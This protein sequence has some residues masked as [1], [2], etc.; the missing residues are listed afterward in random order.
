MVVVVLEFLACA[1]AG[2]VWCVVCGVWCSDVDM[3]CIG[4][5][6]T[7]VTF[8]LVVGCCAGLRVVVA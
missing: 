7:C 3:A 2:A 5:H 1:S 6:R 8:C 4:K